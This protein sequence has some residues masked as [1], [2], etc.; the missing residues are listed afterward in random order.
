MIAREYVEPLYN[1]KLYVIAKCKPGEADKKVIS[2]FGFN[3]EFDPKA[4]ASIIQHE[5]GKHFIMYL[6]KTDAGTIIHEVSHMLDDVYTY[7]GIKHDCACASCSEHRAHQ[8][9]GWLR[10]IQLILK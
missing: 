6:R 10:I 3:P 8:L 9:D 1:V 4:Y 5:D 7:R 2:L